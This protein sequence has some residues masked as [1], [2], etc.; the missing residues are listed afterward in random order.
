MVVNVYDYSG[1]STIHRETILQIVHRVLEGEGARMPGLNIIIADDAY[2][3]DLN[4]HFLDKDRATN[5]LAFPLGE[6]NEI[7]VSIDQAGSETELCYYIVHGLLHLIGYE[8]DSGRAEKR[9]HSQCL[10][11]VHEVFPDHVQ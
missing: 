11:Y 6:V 2:L 7:Y 3:K 4:L 5:V 8:H 1:R 9:M 10:Y